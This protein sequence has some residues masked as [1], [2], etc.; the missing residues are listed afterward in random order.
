M[1][2]QQVLRQVR[3]HFP[4]GLDAEELQIDPR[5]FE[6]TLATLETRQLIVVSR[7]SKTKKRILFATPV[8]TPTASKTMLVLHTRT[9]SEQ[10]W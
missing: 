2:L 8:R 5:F 3:D 1:L 4:R 9:R 6:V 7:D 10:S